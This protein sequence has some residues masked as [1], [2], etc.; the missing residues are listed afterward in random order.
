MTPELP[1]SPLA[2]TRVGRYEIRGALGRGG[3]GAV[4]RAFDPVLGREVAVKTLMP[5]GSEATPAE[6][7][8]LRFQREARAAARLRHPNAIE[9]FDVGVADGVHYLAMELVDGVGIDRWVSTRR[10]W[11]DVA[12]VIE[13]TARALHAAHLEGIVHRDVKPA[14]VLVDS[15]GEPHLGD[16]GLAKAVDLAAGTRLTFSGEILGT[17]AYMSPEQARGDLDEVD[18][19][20]DVFSLGSVLYLCLTGKEA[21]GAQGLART[22]ERVM[23]DDPDLPRRVDP[24]G[25]PDLEAVCVKALEKEPHRRY[26]SA[27]EM[28]DDL[29]RFVAGEP[30]R[31]LRPTPLRLAMRRLRR[32]RVTIAVGLFLIAAS[33]PIAWTLLRSH[34]EASSAHAS[35][36]RRTHAQDMLAALPEAH[37][38]TDRAAL[39]THLVQLGEVVSA[40]PTFGLPL[41]CRGVARQALGD[42]DGALVDFGAAARLDP[43][44]AEAHYRAGFLLLAREAEPG[45]YAAKRAREEFQAAE[46][47]AP[48]S[49]FAQLGEAHL[50]SLAEDWTKALAILDRLCAGTERHADAFILR[51]SLRSYMFQAR[52]VRR[53]RVT[54]EWWDME[55]ALDDLGVAIELDPINPWG[56]AARGM[57]RF[58]AGDLE[59]ARTDLEDSFRIAPEAETAGFAG[60]VAYMQGDREASRRWMNEAVARAR[61]AGFRRFRAFLDFLDREYRRGIVDLDVIVAAAPDDAETRVLRGMLRYAAGDR[62]GADQDLEVYRRADPH[63]LKR[64]AEL[65]ADFTKNRA[66]VLLLAGAMKD[67][68]RILFLPPERKKQLRDVQRLLNASPWFTKALEPLEEAVRNSPDWIGLMLEFSQLA[69]ERDELKGAPE[70][71]V[72]GMGMKSD[73]LFGKEGRLLAR[74]VGERTLLWRKRLSDGAQYLRRGSVRYRSGDNAGALADLEEAARLSPS[75]SDVKYGL[76]TLRALAGTGDEAIR[77]LEQALH[78]GW[79]H[80]EYTRADPDFASIAGRPEFARIVGR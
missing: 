70:F 75:D 20:S 14:N 77:A 56:K 4:F 16:F 31:A 44:L 64:F 54:E 60:R 55:A 24:A 25:P 71:L 21:F 68:D 37:E 17:P 66:A 38:L 47:A 74:I 8:V 69:E 72:K 10:A 32:H 33:V 67:M 73:F 36:D 13:K 76:A 40:D 39:E 6:E 2:R 43:S 57:L 34:E 3:M 12:R 19:R 42:F 27:A 26:G 46:A 53:W 61:G 1:D 52:G 58:D 49:A 5:L 28:A 41:L 45:P 29:A 79:A 65:D 63:N 30:V 22:V 62:A 23:R 59:G 15:K 9:V 35:Q 50:A 78:A 48:G 80:P 11:P 18:P 7:D 51:A